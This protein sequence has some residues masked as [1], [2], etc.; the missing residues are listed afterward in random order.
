MC[1]AEQLALVVPCGTGEIGNKRDNRLVV[2]M[3]VCLF[4][5]TTSESFYIVSKK[6]RA[7]GLTK[8]RFILNKLIKL[9]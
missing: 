7:S 6:I 1:F 9:S 2:V 3:I 5:F 8:L 4:F